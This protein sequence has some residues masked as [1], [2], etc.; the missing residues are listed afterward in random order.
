MLA[1]I[2]GLLTTAA[3]FLLPLVEKLGVYWINAY[4]QD[5]AQKA[6][7]LALFQQFI[8]MHSNDAVTSANE[9]ENDN[10]QLKELATE[11]AKDDEAAAAAKAPQVKVQD[12]EKKNG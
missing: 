8:D 4:F 9:H 11:A 6:Q 5:Q 7:A 2:F 12:G 1:T 3:P 10:D